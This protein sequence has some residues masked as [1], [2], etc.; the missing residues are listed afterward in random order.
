MWASSRQQ[1]H[2]RSWGGG[3]RPTLLP[4]LFAEVDPGQTLKNHFYTSQL[5]SGAA[6]ED[7]DVAA[8]PFLKCVAPSGVQYILI[9]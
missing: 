6:R 7:L 2:G 1:E 9:D 5:G 4:L 3:Q 8:G